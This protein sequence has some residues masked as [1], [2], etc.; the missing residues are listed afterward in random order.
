MFLYRLYNQNKKIIYIGKTEN[1]INLR[2]RA[3][4]THY[5]KHKKARSLWRYKARFFDYAELKNSAELGIYEIYL[6]NKLKPEFNYMDKYKGEVRFSLPELEFEDIKP[7]N[8]VLN[9][10]KKYCQLIKS[11]QQKLLK[12]N[13]NK[14]FEIR[15]SSKYVQKYEEMISRIKGRIRTKKRNKLIFSLMYFLGLKLSEIRNL[16]SNDVNYEKRTIKINSRFFKANDYIFNL[17]NFYNNK[18]GFMFIS[19]HNKIISPRTIQ[20][21]LKKYIGM[22]PTEIRREFTN[23]LLNENKEE[24]LGLKSRWGR[25]TII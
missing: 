11:K 13:K 7:I 22:S 9:N 24:I 8:E 6:I 10:Y 2:I 15:L 12:S 16:K 5:K 17:L 14:F 4:F 21:M 3:H 20:L 19:Q 25:K 18:K 23:N 1:D